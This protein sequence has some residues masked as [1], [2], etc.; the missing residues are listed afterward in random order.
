M[1]LEGLSP[2]QQQGMEQILK[3]GR[4]LLKLIDEVLDIARIE[5]GHLT[6]SDEPVLVST[7]VH[8]AVTL[9]EPLAANCDVR[10]VCESSPALNQHIRAD[11]QRCKQVVLN[12]LSNAIKYNRIGGSVAIKA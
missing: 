7:I 6:L 9:L 8:E 11:Q 12:L 3:G 4:H 10:L 2:D 1:E 5:S